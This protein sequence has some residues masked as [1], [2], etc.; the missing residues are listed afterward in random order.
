MHRFFNSFNKRINADP[1]QP[2]EAGL[3][4]DR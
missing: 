4:A 3:S 1:A 2:G